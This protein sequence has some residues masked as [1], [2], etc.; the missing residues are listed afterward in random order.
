MPVNF[1][2]PFSKVESF[3]IFG[4][5]SIRLILLVLKNDNL[6]KKRIFFKTFHFPEVESFSHSAGRGRVLPSIFKSLIF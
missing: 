5:K 3:H 2:F 1:R 4:L 6:Y